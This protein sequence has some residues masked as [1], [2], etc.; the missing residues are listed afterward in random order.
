MC[1]CTPV[2]TEVVSSAKIGLF[3]AFCDLLLPF[4]N[5]LQMSSH[6]TDSLVSPVFQGQPRILLF[7]CTAVFPTN[8]L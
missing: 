2:F 1:S 7:A 4:N 8:P 3:S 5:I 6:V